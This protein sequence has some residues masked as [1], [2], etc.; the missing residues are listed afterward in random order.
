M[1]DSNICPCILKCLILHLCHYEFC[2]LILHIS[3]PGTKKLLNSTCSKSV[4]A[5]SVVTGGPFC[6]NGVMPYP[7]I[8]CVVH[9]PEHHAGKETHTGTTAITSGKLQMKG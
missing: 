5:L 9:R 1:S 2:E 3:I 6:S 4:W 8:K 7:F